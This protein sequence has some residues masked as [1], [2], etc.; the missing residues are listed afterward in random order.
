MSKRFIDLSVTIEDGLPSDPPD[1]IP[2]IEYLVRG[3]G[4]GRESTL[5]ILDMGVHVVGTDAWS[6][7]RPL[8][9]IAREFQESGDASIIREAHFAG[10]EKGYFQTEREFP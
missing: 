1:L 4:M 8:P 2:R 3:C 7:D 10:R 9:S 6:W 5:H